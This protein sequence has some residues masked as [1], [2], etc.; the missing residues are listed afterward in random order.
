MK[1]PYETV[2]V[3]DG[4]LPDDVLQKEQKLLEDFLKQ[5][6]ADFEKVDVWGKRMLAYPVKKR[7][8]GF[9][10]MFLYEAEGDIAGSIDKYVKLNTAILRHLTVIRNVKNDKARAAVFARREKPVEPEIEKMD[11]E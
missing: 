1:R 9:Y 7:K 2:V 11:E 8:T 5:N 3:F 4:T 6:N 10:C